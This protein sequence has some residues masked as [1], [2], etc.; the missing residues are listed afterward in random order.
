MVPDLCTKVTTG[1]LSSVTS[2]WLTSPWN[3]PCPHAWRGPAPFIPT[4]ACHGS[5]LAQLLA[6]HPALWIPLQQGL[7]NDL[8]MSVFSDST[9]TSFPVTQHKCRSSCHG[10]EALHHATSM[11]ALPG[12]SSL[13]DFYTG[14]GRP[15]GL[16]FT[17]LP[18]LGPSP[19]SGVSSNA[20]HVEVLVSLQVPFRACHSFTACPPHLTHCLFP[21]A[22]PIGPNARLRLT[23]SADGALWAALEAQGLVLHTIPYRVSI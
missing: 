1:A 7:L 3:S 4:P 20:P 8:I 14:C 18:Q 22:Q 11:Q 10:L 13:R 12:C 19:L 17:D 2:Y 6:P 15:R 21:R 16:L 5:L 23:Q 9:H